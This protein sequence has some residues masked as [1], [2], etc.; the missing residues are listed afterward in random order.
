MTLTPDSRKRW[1]AWLTAILLLPALLAPGVLLGGLVASRVLPDTGMGWDQLANTLGGMMVGAI[2]AVGAWLFALQQLG[3]RGRLL[4]TGGG[5]VAAIVASVVLV[6][7]RPQNQ[8]ASL[9]LHEGQSL[10]VQVKSVA[11]LA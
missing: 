3:T 7:T 5:L 1:S 2:L 8:A 10:W 9:Q 4:L 11:L 6:T